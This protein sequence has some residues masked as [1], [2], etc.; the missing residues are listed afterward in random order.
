MSGS[1]Q[2][3]FG[4]LYSLFP[5]KRLVLTSLVIFFV[6][7]ILSALA[8]TSPVFIIGRAITGL[9]TAGI[10]SGAFAFVPHLILTGQMD[11]EILLTRVY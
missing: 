6:G 4:K 9:A 11:M 7:S 8:S 2:L 5:A 3:L 10:T 1:F